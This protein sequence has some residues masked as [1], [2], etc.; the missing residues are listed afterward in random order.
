MGN[1]ELSVIEAETMMTAT[2][3]WREEMKIDEIMTEE[4]PD[5]IFAGVGRIFGKDK[6]GRPI[7]CVISPHQR[8]LT[9]LSI[10]DIMYTVASRT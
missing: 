9:E 3:K 10:S 6:G 7:M 2:L 8:L 4:F 1:R 5:K